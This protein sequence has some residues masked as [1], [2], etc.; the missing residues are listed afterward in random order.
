VPFI[1]KTIV[2][3]AVRRAECQST[4]GAA[5]KHHVG[6]RSPRRLH[7]GQHV[8]VVISE[9][10]RAVNRK[11]HHSIQSSWIDPALDDGT[12]EVNS[13]VSVKSRCLAPDLCV[14]RSNAAKC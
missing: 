14:A 2:I 4:V 8:N 1:R 9:T 6:C 13:G 12:A 10:A 5:H 11:E 7:T 3:D